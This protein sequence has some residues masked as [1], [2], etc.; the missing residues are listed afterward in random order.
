MEPVFVRDASTGKLLS[1]SAVPFTRVPQKGELI[2]TQKRLWSVSRVVHDWVSPGVPVS[3]IEVSPVESH[4]G[5][6]G[7]NA[8]P[9]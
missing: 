9:F 1:E 2:A 8:T 5:P 3:W 6:T 4:T 7:S